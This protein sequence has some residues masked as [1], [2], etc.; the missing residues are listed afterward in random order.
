MTLAWAQVLM[1]PLDVANT[2]GMGG[3]I[4]MDLFWIIIYISIAVFVFVINPG[5]SYWY[6]SDPD[7]STV[8]FIKLVGEDKILVCI[9]ICNTYSSYCIINSFIRILVNCI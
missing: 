1:L 6:E 4:R 7:W 8:L 3:G 2:R 5:L 9:S